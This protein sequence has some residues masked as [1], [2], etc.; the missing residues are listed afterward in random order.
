MPTSQPF[1]TNPRRLRRIASVVISLAAVSV[2]L[3]ACG[4]PEPTPSPSE[5]MSPAP[6]AG[7]PSSGEPGEPGGGAT[8][9][10]E[11]PVPPFETFTADSLC[12]LA[13]YVDAA[14]LL[15]TGSLAWEPFD[16]T[17]FGQTD[18]VG[19]RIMSTASLG[20]LELRGASS[21]DKNELLVLTVPG[22]YD[23]VAHEIP[24]A[25]NDT[26]PQTIMQW[27]SVLTVVAKGLYVQLEVLV[28]P[29]D[30]ALPVTE[31]ELFDELQ[32]VLI[33]AGLTNA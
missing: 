25:T 4:P 7:E 29:R 26:P 23:F 24:A 15:G 6:S 22:G 2:G 18:I 32:A 19:C 31:D 30:R 1:A 11:V 21:K 5:T 16:L 12:D 3:T 27:S 17:Q 33:A 13:V 20:V 10:G 9:D 14:P 8:W 28:D